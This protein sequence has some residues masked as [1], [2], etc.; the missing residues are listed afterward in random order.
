[1]T[2]FYSRLKP[3]PTPAQKA[4]HPVQNSPQRQEINTKSLDNPSPIPHSAGQTRVAEETHRI[5]RPAS[6][7]TDRSVPD[8]SNV[9]TFARHKR[10][11]PKGRMWVY[12]L[13]RFADRKLSIPIIV[14]SNSLLK[15]L[16]P[17]LQHPSLTYSTW[18]HTPKSRNWSHHIT[19]HTSVLLVSMYHTSFG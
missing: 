17:S 9:P 13:W 6:N 5:S 18:H 1:M 4:V 7:F 14:P 12:A 8:D 3:P 15:V 10:L 16:L 2:F 11:S 19:P